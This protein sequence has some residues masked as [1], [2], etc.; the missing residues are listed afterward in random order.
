[1]IVLAWLGTRFGKVSQSRDQIQCR[2]QSLKPLFEVN[3][4]TLG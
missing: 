4:R 3:M 1:M 2:D